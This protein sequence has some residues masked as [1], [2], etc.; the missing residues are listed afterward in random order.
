[1]KPKE[2]RVF[3]GTFDVAELMEEN[4]R[5]VSREKELIELIEAQATQ[6]ANLEQ[7]SLLLTAQKLKLSHELSRLRREIWEAKARLHQRSMN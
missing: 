5:L 1:M 6:S 2:T 7:L 4:K 3:Y